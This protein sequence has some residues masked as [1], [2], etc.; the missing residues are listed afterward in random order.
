MIKR[1]L[2]VFM[3]LI[4]VLQTS[5]IAFGQTQEHIEN[6]DFVNLESIE[7]YI[8]DNYS[9]KEAD[10]IIENVAFLN[11]H[12]ISSNMLKDI[13]YEADEVSFKYLLESGIEADI[14]INEYEDGGKIYD[15][16]EG[17]KSNELIICEDG[18]IILDGFEVTGE[19]EVEVKSNN[20][21]DAHEVLINGAETKSSE[22][23]QY[24][25]AILR[26]GSTTYSV[27]KCPYGKASDYNVYKSTVKNKN[28]ELGQ[29]LETITASALIL[30][31]CTWATIYDAPKGVSISLGVSYWIAEKLIEAGSTSYGIS[32]TADRY[33]YK[34]GQYAV[35]GSSLCVEKMVSKWYS[36]TKYNGKEI[37]KTYYNCKEYY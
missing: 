21:V 8:T 13:S 23:G 7:N 35:Q 17:D 1:K 5:G 3:S 9:N 36:E 26:A 37:D 19:E 31:I 33:Y 15:I 16:I 22:D 12:G 4:M 10:Y 25:S 32:Y 27:E 29:K 18:K 11:E 20:E 24:L 34:T 28:I 14:T 2:S 6:D 30:V